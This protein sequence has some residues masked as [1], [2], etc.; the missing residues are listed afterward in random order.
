MIKSALIL[1]F[2]AAI[3]GFI[4]FTAIDRFTK[5]VQNILVFAGAYLFSLTILHILPELFDTG[6]PHFQLGIL[7]LSGFFFQQFLELFTNGV[8]HGHIHVHQETDRHSNSQGLSLM[9]ALSIHAF[10]EG[11][12]LSHPETIHASHTEGSLLA[13]IVLHKLPAAIALIS[14]LSCHYKSVKTQIILLILFGL[15]S[16]LGV[17][18]GHFAEGLTIINDN[19]MVLLFAFVAGNFLHISTTIFFEARPSHHWSGKKFGISL[20]GAIVA[21]AAELLI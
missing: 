17:L 15:A 8:E 2:A 9:I 11:T 12:L 20:L 19:T 5:N 6:L 7:I 16:P 13:G 3:G 1:F 14:I 18:T 10:L 21:V 4:G